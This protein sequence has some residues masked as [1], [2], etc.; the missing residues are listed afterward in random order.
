MKKF[1]IV[2]LDCP[3]TLVKSA[4]RV[5]EAEP[6]NF[7]KA[8]IDSLPDETVDVVMLG[9]AQD[10]I[11]YNDNGTIRT[12]PYFGNPKSIKDEFDDDTKIIIW[13]GRHIFNVE[14]PSTPSQIGAQPHL[15]NPWSA[16]DYERLCMVKIWQV[17]MYNLLSSAVIPDECK[18]FFLVTD[19]RLPLIELNKVDPVAVPKPLPKGII[20]LTQAHQADAYNKW[21][22]KYGNGLN[23]PEMDITDY[24]Y[25]FDNVMYLPLHALPIWSHT[26]Y[27]KHIAD[28]HKCSIFQV[29]SMKYIDDYRK[30]KLGQA[31]KFVD[32]K[33]TLHGRF[34]SA[35]RGIVVA[36][37][38]DFA[39][40]LL[41]HCIDNS[42]KPN[43][44]FFDSTQILADHQASL[45]ITD[46]RYARFGLCPNRFVEAIATGTIPLHVKG[47]FEHCDDTLKSIVKD[48]DIC[49]DKT[50][51]DEDGRVHVYNSN[52]DEIKATVLEDKFKSGCDTL[53]R[54]LVT[55]LATFA[56]KYWD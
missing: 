56:N 55:A 12:V 43:E 40:S 23:Y 51:I 47:V 8:L 50:T 35:E 32:G 5:P 39:D 49:S 36:A 20:L 33:C 46:Q 53:K 37:Y 29:Q 27:R 28:K 11:E 10:Q 22:A 38:P 45:I 24:M 30:K 13:Q 48:L 6:L 14:M 1:A 34:L 4:M 19:L 2:K 18:M 7:A 54:Q 25:N 16:G 15:V 21:Q 44:C 42:D 9:H 26:Q 17:Q 52:G 3:C 41:E 31:L